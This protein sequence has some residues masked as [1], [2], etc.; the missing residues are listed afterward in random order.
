MHIFIA[1]VLYWIYVQ[2]DHLLHITLPGSRIY[3][4]SWLQK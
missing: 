3:N 4:S 2:K 1:E